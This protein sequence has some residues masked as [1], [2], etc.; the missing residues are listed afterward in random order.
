MTTSFSLHPQLAAD[1]A[2]VGDLPLSRLL[3]MRDRRFPWCILVPRIPDL[4]ELHDLPAGERASWFSELEAVS[5][6][7]LDL[8]RI[9]KVNVGALGNL[10]PQ[11][12]VHVVGRHPR[13]AAW[14]GPVWGSGPAEEL[15]DE[16]TARLAAGLRDAL[17]P[18]L[19][20]D[21]TGR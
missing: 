9:T 21:T 18:L 7:V 12:H 3:L 11:L 13:D 19:R 2:E 15:S 17:G 20:N 1:C 10:V 6:A 16:Q 8:A 4:R 14:P 5:R